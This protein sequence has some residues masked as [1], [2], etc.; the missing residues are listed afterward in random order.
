MKKETSVS[1]DKDKTE[2]NAPEGTD[3]AGLPQEKCKNRQSGSTRYGI[4]AA[5]QEEVE[6]KREPAHGMPVERGGTQEPAEFD[7]DMPLLLD[8]I[9]PEEILGTMGSMGQK[10]EEGNQ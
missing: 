6:S 10:H 9:S 8:E 2:H 1:V 5:S 4:P 7:D 3:T